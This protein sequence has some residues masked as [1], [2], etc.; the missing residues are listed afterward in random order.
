MSVIP[1]EF[2]T[3]PSRPFASVCLIEVEED[4]D[5]KPCMADGVLFYLTA[6]SCYPACIDH[7][8]SDG[9]YHEDY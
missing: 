8:N 9:A 6:D 2:P 5:R 7:A 1:F 3:I 4:G